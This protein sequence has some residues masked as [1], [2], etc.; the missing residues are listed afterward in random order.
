MSSLQTAA[1]AQAIDWMVLMRSGSAKEGDVA[2]FEAWRSSAPEHQAAYEQVARALGRLEPLKARGVPAKQ[3]HRLLQ[4]NSRRAALRAAMGI[5]GMTAGAGILGW[6]VSREAGMWADESTSLAQRRQLT[7]PEQA[8]LWLDA[9]TQI[10]RSV[11]AQGQIVTLH[12]GRVLADNT[13]SRLPLLLRTCCVS[14]FVPQGQG[15]FVMHDRGDQGVRVST[16]QGSVSIAPQNQR[17]LLVPA[18][19]RAVLAQNEPA[20]LEP[21][22]GDEEL[23]TRGLMA[24]NDEPLGELVDALRAYRGG[25]IRVSPEAARLRISGVF[26]LD[27]TDRTLRALDETQPLR[28][29]VVAR[30][31]VS[32]ERV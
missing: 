11:D 9:R 22:R 24:L 23:W 28:V 17:P 16:L 1:L 21:S 19:M 4:R 3:A 30:Y 7:P 20:R 29:S 8:A 31:W 15:R 26:S 10:D 14:A 2:A 13:T 5:A 18:G 27:D 6:Q 32:I 12:R 25:V